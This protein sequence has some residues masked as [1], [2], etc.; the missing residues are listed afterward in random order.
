MGIKKRTQDFL[1][2]F[3][4][5][6]RIR[7]AVHGFA[8]RW[9]SHSSKAPFFLCD[10]K[11]QCYLQSTKCCSIFFIFL[12]I[13]RGDPTRTGD[14]LVPNQ[15]RF[16]LRYTPNLSTLSWKAMQRYIFIFNCARILDV[17]CIFCASKSFSPKY[18][19]VYRIFCV[20]LHVKWL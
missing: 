6:W 15:V 8:D 1:E 16:Q 20:F 14:H 13:C 5:A 3:R 17:F 11:V 19:N 10:A 12:C 7:T 2:F 9:L 4:G 18:N